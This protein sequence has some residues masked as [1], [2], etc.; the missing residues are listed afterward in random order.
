MNNLENLL[1]RVEEILTSRN[2]ITVEVAELEAALGD[3]SDYIN[4][5]RDK[6]DSDSD[7]YDSSELYVIEGELIEY[8]Y[9]EERINELQDKLYN[10]NADNL[11]KGYDLEEYITEQIQD[12]YSTEL[13]NLPSFIEIDWLKT[14][15]NARQDYSSIDLKWNGFTYG[16]YY[17]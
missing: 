7:D 4:E 16:F 6:I 13:E 11:I 3:I 14:S 10:I 8:G 17:N 12:A 9:N 2:S 5:L 1:N 15:F